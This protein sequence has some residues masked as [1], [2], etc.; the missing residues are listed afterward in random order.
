MIFFSILKNTYLFQL[1]EGNTKGSCWE[2]KVPNVS[3]NEG[4]MMFL[5]VT[6]CTLDLT[7]SPEFVFFSIQFL[8]CLSS[9]F[10]ISSAQKTCIFPLSLPFYYGREDWPPVVAKHSF[11]A[12]KKMYIRVEE[13]P[14]IVWTI[15]L[16]S[17][18]ELLQRPSFSLSS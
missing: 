8:T 7:I 6:C 1:D 4:L 16:I 9:I 2:I 18:W 12:R 14:R 3:R 11:F 5:S 10:Y 13:N 17:S 15:R